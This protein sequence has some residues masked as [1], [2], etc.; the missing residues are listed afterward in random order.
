MSAA[1]EQL[2]NHSASLINEPAQM[3]PIDQ[4]AYCC[5][6]SRE[7][8]SLGIIASIQKANQ[9]GAAD[10]ISGILMW[11]ERLMIHWLEGTAQALD[12]L[13]QQV[14]NDASQHCVVLLMR[15]RN[16]PARLF[17]NWRIQA[18]HRQDMMAVVREAKAQ[19]SRDP[20]PQALQWQH[21]ISTLSILL[22][23]KLTTFYAL[24][25]SSAHISPWDSMPSSLD[26]ALS[27][28]A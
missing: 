16:A 18:T 14:Q 22:D 17:P 4:M 12:G 28:G 25:A 21:A 19:A 27:M 5:I 24:S 3:A 8:G 13:W 1:P 10:A 15:R 26:P 2:A 11:D 9:A 20:D 7:I 23:P 6:A